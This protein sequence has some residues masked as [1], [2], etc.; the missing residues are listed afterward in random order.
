M[1]NSL[2]IGG[3]RCAIK[4]ENISAAV[5]EDCIPLG[6]FQDVPAFVPRSSPDPLESLGSSSMEAKI[7][8]LRSVWLRLGDA[9]GDAKKSEKLEEFVNGAFS[10]RPDLDMRVNCVSA[11]LRNP[12]MFCVNRSMHLTSLDS[13]L[14]SSSVPKK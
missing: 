2:T 1:L 11:E 9:I 14:Y 13:I 12:P 3:P 7:L 4:I 6:M 5:R 8:V 10:S